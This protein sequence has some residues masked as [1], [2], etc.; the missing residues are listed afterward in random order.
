MDHS[1]DRL[2]NHFGIFNECSPWV[3]I[4]K[5]NDPDIELQS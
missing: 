3:K 1:F 2:K 5:K 4:T